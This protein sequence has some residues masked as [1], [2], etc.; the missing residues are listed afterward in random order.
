MVTSAHI[1]VQLPVVDAQLLHQVLSLG[2]DSLHLLSLFVGCG[3]DP[4]RGGGQE[5]LDD[6]LAVLDNGV[7]GDGVVQS[8][9][10]VLGWLD[11]TRFPVIR[12]AKLFIDGLSRNKLLQVLC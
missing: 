10:L 11:E 7:S 2:L 6:P 1:G 8:V 9:V 12:A 5:L 3:V 4:C